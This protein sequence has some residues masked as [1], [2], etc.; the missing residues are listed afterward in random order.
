MT[1]SSLHRAIARATGES[2]GTIRRL[3]FTLLGSPDS[4]H[5]PSGAHPSRLVDWDEVDANRIRVLPVRRT[6]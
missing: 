3:G 6:V 2:L 5:G 4:D 1:R